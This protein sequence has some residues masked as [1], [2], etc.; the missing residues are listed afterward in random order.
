[1]GCVRMNELL[2]IVNTAGTGANPFPWPSGTT[3]VTSDANG[4]ILAMSGTGWNI[5]QE[6][7]YEQRVKRVVRA[8]GTVVENVYDGMGRRVKETVGGA[9]KDLVSMEGKVLREYDG[10]GNL[11]A[12][13]FWAG[14][15]LLQKDLW[16]QAGVRYFVP[17]ALRTPFSS[18]DQAGSQTFRAMYN[19]FGVATSTTGTNPTPYEWMGNWRNGAS[20]GL[21]SFKNAFYYPE[22][23]RNLQGRFS[24]T[25]FNGGV[26]PQPCLMIAEIADSGFGGAG[27]FGCGGG[28]VGPPPPPGGPPD[29]PPVRDGCNCPSCNIRSGPV[30]ITYTG[31][32]GNCPD[33]MA[34]F[35]V[36][37][38]GQEIG[39]FESPQE[40][41]E[42][43]EDQL[44]R[45]GCK[46][47][48]GGGPGAGE[49]GGIGGGLGREGDFRVGGLRAGQESKPCTIIRMKKECCEGPTPRDCGGAPGNPRKC[50]GGNFNFVNCSETAKTKVIFILT[51]ICTTLRTTKCLESPQTRDVCQCMQSLCNCN[52]PLKIYCGGE[53][54]GKCSCCRGRIKPCFE[55]YPNGEEVLC[56]C[57]VG[58]LKERDLFHELVHVCTQWKE[59]VP[60]APPEVLANGCVTKCYGKFNE[61]NPNCCMDAPRCVEAIRA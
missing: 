22:L 29:I 33:N 52:K 57:S 4:N 59:N 25:F 9:G 24:L 28:V 26:R 36:D 60:P 39:R 51:N 6:F 8:D 18:W 23:G 41:D 58:H 56:I 53:S 19:S 11:T 30:G 37:C 43:V 44:K 40:A 49:G 42:Y 54:N 55:R 31:Y 38:Q 7:D 10:A 13:Y 15:D 14:F 46:E 34:L 20:H 32:V 2:Q 50:G 45:C 1:M 21:L 12:Q 61:Y 3:T 35:C 17:N 5:S 48:N 16:G 27:G 47:C